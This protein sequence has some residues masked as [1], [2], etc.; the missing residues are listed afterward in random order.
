MQP[1]I[2]ADIDSHPGINPGQVE[3][4]QD[5]ELRNAFAPDFAFGPQADLLTTSGMAARFSPYGS[6]EEL[7]W[8]EGTSLGRLA[9]GGQTWELDIPCWILDI[10][11]VSAPF[12]ASSWLFSIF[13]PL[14]VLLNPEL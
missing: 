11:F 2:N 4:A 7:R 13:Y 1:P 8:P 14:S 10:Q 6:A 5:A 3:K 12:C 9:L